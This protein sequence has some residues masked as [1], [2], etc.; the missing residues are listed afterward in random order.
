MSLKTIILG[1]IIILA[2]ISVASASEAA[3]T[4]GPG[5]GTES[6]AALLETQPS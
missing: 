5:N 3:Q 2:L 1:P 4:N 6:I